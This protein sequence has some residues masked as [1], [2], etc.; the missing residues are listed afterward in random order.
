MRPRRAG[1]GQRGGRAGSSAVRCASGRH[2]PGRRRQRFGVRPVVRGSSPRALYPLRVAARYFNRNAAESPIQIPVFRL[3]APAC[4]TPPTGIP[5]GAGRRAHRPVR[6]VASA[7]PSAIKRAY[8]AS[9][10]WSFRS[11]PLSDASCG[12]ACPLFCACAC[13]YDV[14][15][16]CVRSSPPPP[17]PWS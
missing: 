6:C 8:Y 13:A 2:A 11:C 4:T 3:N 16:S 17:P 1:I 14:V 7:P 15:A 12:G 10:L 9:S 5:G